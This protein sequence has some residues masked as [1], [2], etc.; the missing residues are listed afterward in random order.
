M[1]RMLFEKNSKKKVALIE[2]DYYRVIF[3]PPGGGGKLNSATIHKMIYHN[4]VTALNDGYD[5]ILE[6]ILSVKS[7]EKVLESIFKKHPKENYLFY[8]DISF[9]ETIRRHG[10]RVVKGKQFGRKEMQEWYPGSHRSNHKL[11]M[12]IPESYSIKQTIAF[13]KKKTG[14]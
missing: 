8:F 2:Q 5:V 13:I 7:Y 10:T 14:L 6:G 9:E 3:N 4:V 12:L 11:E 1:A